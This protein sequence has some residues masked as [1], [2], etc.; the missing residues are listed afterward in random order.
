MSEIEFFKGS[1]FCYRVFDVSFEI[2]LETLKD[3]LTQ[4]GLSRSFEFKRVSRNLVMSHMPLLVGVDS[5]KQ[6]FNNK[7]YEINAFAKV[8]SFGAVSVCLQINVEAG[9]PWRD[10]VL[11]SAFLDSDPAIH[12]TCAGLAIKLLE[13]I[14]PKAE[15]LKCLWNQCEDYIL[16]IYDPGF[17]HA[18]HIK[19]LIQNESVM[20]LVMLQ[21][22]SKLS[23]QMKHSFLATIFQYG[24]DDLAAIEWNCGFVCSED[25]SQDIADVLEFALTQ[26]TELRYFDDL[27]DR[28]LASLYNATKQFG[29][30]IF[31]SQYSKVANEASSLYIEIS[32]TVEKVENSIKVVG[33]FYYAKIYRAA[34]EKFRI[35]DWQ[36]SIDTKLNNLIEVSRVLKSDVDT[37]R[38]LILEIAV[39]VLFLI[40][41]FPFFKKF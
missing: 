39:V 30:R 7:T 14:K 15:I 41:V 36:G 35:K 28:K 40:E 38:A 5:W 17:Y 18:E 16:F 27:L 37:R 3:K 10:A 29:P 11:F 12:D 13:N 6:V 31:S 22:P 32:Q 24:P 23:E 2:D 33:D 9:V 4:T 21:E 1:I 8:F 19:S 25:D 20:H 26:L 34:V